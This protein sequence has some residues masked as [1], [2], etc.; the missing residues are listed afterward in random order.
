MWVTLKCGVWCVN[1]PPT[2]KD[3]FVN[4]W[5]DHIYIYILR[6]PK[7]EFPICSM[8]NCM[9][10]AETPL[11]NTGRSA[12]TY[13]KCMIW[14][15]NFNKRFEMIQGWIIHNKIKHVNGEKRGDNIFTISHIPP[16]SFVCCIF[17]LQYHKPNGLWTP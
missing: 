9:N 14:L 8:M 15:K 3:D 16:K 17:L 4:K 13:Y 1:R 5:K 6:K 7:S 2:H 10:A 12:K 11:T